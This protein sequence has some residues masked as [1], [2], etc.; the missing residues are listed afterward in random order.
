MRRKTMTLSRMPN[1]SCRACHGMGSI[2][3]TAHFHTGDT[4]FEAPCWECY[5]SEV[6]LSFP[7]PTTSDN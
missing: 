6:K 2:R 4:E 5:G 7:H 3:L 1:S